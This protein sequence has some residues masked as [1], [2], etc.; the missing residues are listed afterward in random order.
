[1]KNSIYTLLILLLFSCKSQYVLAQNPN[2]APFIG[3]WEYQ[4]NNQIFRVTIYED[5]NDLKGDY[6]L[7]EI[8]NGNETI[9]YESD[10]SAPNSDFNWGYA[11]F[12]GSNDGNLMYAKIDDNSIG[13]ENGVASRKRKRGSLGLTIQPQTCSTCPITAE[14]KVAELQGLK[15]TGEPENYNIPTD[16][17]LTK[18]E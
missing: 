18:V 1:M 8:D 6:L 4:E 7:L 9:I 12:G 2:H 17:I 14:W 13:Y 10:Y 11:I 5:G 15:I 16:I 3:T